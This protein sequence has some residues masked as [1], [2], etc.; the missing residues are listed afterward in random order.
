MT[1]T[2]LQTEQHEPKGEMLFCLAN[3]TYLLDVIHCHT[4]YPNPLRVTQATAN[5]CTELV[6]VPIQYTI[7][8]TPSPTQGFPLSKQGFSSQCEHTGNLFVSKYLG[9][10]ISNYL[11]VIAVCNLLTLGI[12]K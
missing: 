5:R 1:V 4:H 2:V 11:I 3:L 9:T 8:N 6:Q 7:F 10:V 12:E